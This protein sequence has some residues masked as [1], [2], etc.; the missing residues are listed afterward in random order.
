MDTIKE[1]AENQTIILILSGIE[2][3][4]GVLEVARQLSGQR[5]AYVTL[6]K[7]FSAMK[8]DFGKEG[9]D[10]SKFVFVDGITKTIKKVKGSTTACYY[11]SSPAAL[12]EIS[13]A[14]SKILARGFRYVLFDSLTNLPIY[15]GKAPVA[16]FVSGT[17]AMIKERKGMAIFYALGVKEQDG[18]IQESGMSVDK[19][20]D[21]RMGGC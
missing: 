2:Y 16:R 7:T 19:I 12:D 13:G 18:F 17:V 4:R 1:L 21:L 9:I 5:V 11:V 8:D 10:A 6:N 15:G 3:H 14:L 20:I